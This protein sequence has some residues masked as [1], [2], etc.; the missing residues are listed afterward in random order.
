MFS[1]VARSASKVLGQS[2]RTPIP[3]TVDASAPP[4]PKMQ[5][6]YAWDYLC[7]VLLPVT[8]LGFIGA[9]TV[10]KK[11]I[12]TPSLLVVGA[13]TVVV[14][15]FALR[16]WSQLKNFPLL[17]PMAGY[18]AAVI[19]SGI[20]SI[21]HL[22]WLRGVL[23]TGV[24]FCFVVYPY[25]FLRNRQQLLR[26]IHVL[27]AL[28]VLTVSFVFLQTFWFNEMPRFMRVLYRV[29]DI[30]WISSWTA[31]GRVVGNWIHPG[32]LSSLLD[33]MAPLPLLFYFQEK[34]PRRFVWLGVFSYL[35]GC[36]L[37]ANTRTSA[38]ALAISVAL[39]GYL[40]R[41]WRKTVLALLCALAMGVVLPQ[42]A[43]RY[44]KPVYISAKEFGDADIL[45]RF[46]LFDIRNLR[47]I[48]MRR[49]TQRVALELF[50]GH[51]LFGIGM[52]N[53]P[54]RAKMLDPMA[55][56]SVHNIIVQHLTETGLLG[57]FAFTILIIAAMRSDFQ[58]SRWDSGDLQ[59]I[60]YALLASSVAVL[61]ES[62]A[63]NSLYVWQVAATFWLIR[64]MALTISARP[65]DFVSGK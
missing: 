64:G 30:W 60:R 14:A 55:A 63:K 10:G 54:D 19:L 1:A 35:A 33:L 5:Q 49:I 58:R 27:I 38:I 18:L 23:E 47:T 28:G 8:F 31:G 24:S 17:W 50:K 40:M 2:E 62:L 7:Y 65:K 52:R 3:I 25:F 34:R 4:L 44:G 15:L 13:S 56:F 43:H 39:F 51:P 53:Y 45:E 48:E 41:N 6:R 37:L 42:V 12:V 36:L 32:F 57:L 22:H 26:G 21:S 59:S 29:Q 61:L 16:H 9:F 11:T 20:H 46:E